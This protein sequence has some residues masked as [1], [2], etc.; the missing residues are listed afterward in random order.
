MAYLNIEE[1][2]QG[3]LT[4]LARFTSLWRMLFEAISDKAPPHASE[5]MVDMLLL[6]GADILSY[7]TWQNAVLVTVRM[8]TRQVLIRIAR[9]LQR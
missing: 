5:D 2:P 9:L 4:A 7:S 3:S 6:P 8:C 1:D